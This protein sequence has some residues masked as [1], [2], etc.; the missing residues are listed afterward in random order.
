M[1]AD[2]RTGKGTGI[3]IQ[4]LAIA[5][6]R[7]SINYTISEVAADWNVLMLMVSQYILQPSFVHVAR[8]SILP[9]RAAYRHTIS[10]VRRT[11]LSPYK[12]SLHFHYEVPVRY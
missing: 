4:V 2:A 3:G 10:S 8:R 7:P 11:G 9:F 1:A 6:I 5:L 12:P